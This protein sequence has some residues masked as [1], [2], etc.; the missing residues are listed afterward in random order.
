M[1]GTGSRGCGRAIWGLCWTTAGCEMIL[2]RRVSYQAQTRIATFLTLRDRSV[3]TSPGMD[4]SLNTSD[5]SS[6]DLSGRNT[7]HIVNTHYDD[8]GKKSRGWASW[9]I[10]VM[11]EDWVKSG[12]ERDGGEEGVTH[13][14]LIIWMGDFSRFPDGRDR[15]LELIG[16]VLIALHRRS[17]GR[18]EGERIH[19]RCFT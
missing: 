11:A 17:H 15:L 12:A 2:M 1:L 13:D 14:D 3:P 18:P 10:R 16:R 6:T 8:Q 19:P 7:I 9:L 4:S 5:S